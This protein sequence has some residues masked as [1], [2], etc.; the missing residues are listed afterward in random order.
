MLCFTGRQ[1]YTCNKG[2]GQGCSFFQWADEN[3]EQAAAATQ[4]WGAG[5]GQQRNYN[6]NPAPARGFRGRGG[7][8]AG[9]G[10][11]GPRK[12]GQCGEEGM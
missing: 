7:R 9:R 3:P 11:A 6:Y 8:G 10:G 12:C 4:R 2:P 1:F 5:D